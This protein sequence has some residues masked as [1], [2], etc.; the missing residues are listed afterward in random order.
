M[1]THKL[2][3]STRTLHSRALHDHWQDKWH[4][5][6]WHLRAADGSEDPHQPSPID[7]PAIEVARQFGRVSAVPTRC[8]APAGGGGRVEKCDSPMRSRCF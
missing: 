8:A 7:R 4:D 3:E 2:A 6:H 1:L 5:D